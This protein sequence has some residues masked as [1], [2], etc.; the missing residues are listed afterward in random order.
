MYKTAG[1]HTCL[2]Y[3]EREDDPL[4]QVE[5]EQED[6][7]LPTRFAVALPQREDPPLQVDDECDLHGDLDCLDDAVHDV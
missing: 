3:L 6:R 2:L 4:R 1:S 5:Q 7:D